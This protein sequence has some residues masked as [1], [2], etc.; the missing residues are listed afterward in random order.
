MAA[1]SG[2]FEP[3]LAALDGNGVRAVV[4]GGVATV[5]HGH[6]RLTADLDLVVDLR[7]DQ[8]SRAIQALTDL[9]LVPMLPV[10]ALDFADPAIRQRWVATRNLK[11][12]SLYDPA[13]PLRQVDL[14]AED[15][16][17]FDE[18]WGRAVEVRL[19]SVSVRIASIDDLITMKRSAGRPQDLADIEA[20]E[21]IRGRGEP[22]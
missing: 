20:L 7:A 6:A 10:D 5:L 1:A 14:F 11:V 15:P 18:L 13:D 8:P 17:P 4:V 2:L 22:Q 19:A 21:M 3:I 9:G 16:I 12:F